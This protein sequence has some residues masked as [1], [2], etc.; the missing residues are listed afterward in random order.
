MRY[1]L[2]LL[3]IQQFERAAAADLRA[4]RRSGARSH[5]SARRRD[6]DRPLGRAGRDARTRSADARKALDRLRERTRRSTKANPV[7]LHA[8]PWCG[9]T[10]DAWQYGSPTEPRDCVIRCRDKSCAFADGLPVYVVDEDIY[11]VPADADH[12]DRR[13]VRD[14]CRGARRRRRSSTAT[15]D[16]PPP[17]LIIQD[18]L[19]LISGPLGTL[20]GLYETAI[21]VLCTRRRATAEGR[22]PRRRRSAAPQHQTRGLFDREMRQFPPPGLDAR[23]S[24]FAV[25][26]PA[27]R[28]GT[29]LYVGLMAPGASQATLMIRTYAALLQSAL[30]CRGQRRRRGTRTGRSSATS[31]A[32]ACSAAPACRCRTTSHDRL[33]LLAGERR[34]RRSSPTRASSSPAASRRRRSP[35]HLKRM[36]DR[37]PRRRR[38]RRHPRDEHDLGRRRHRPARPDGRDGP[39]AVD[40]RVHP[41]DEPRR[42]AATPGWS[43][44]CSTRRARATAR[45]TRRSRATTRALPP[46]RVDERHAV[47]AARARPRAPRGPDRPRAADDPGLARQR[48]GRSASRSTAPSSSVLDRADRRRGPTGRPGRGRRDRGG[49]R[50]SP[51]A[52]EQR[53]D[54]RRRPAVQLVHATLDKTLLLDAAERPTARSDTCPTPVVAARRRPGVEPLP[55]EE[56]MARSRARS[57]AVSS[58]R[59]TASA[60]SSRSRT[61]RSWSPASTAGTSASPNLH[62]P[63]LETRA[64]RPR[65]RRAAGHATATDI[66]VVRFPRWYSCPNASG[67]TITTSSPTLRLEQVRRLQPHAR[68]VALRGRLRARPHRRLPVHALGA[69]GQAAR[70]RAA[71]LTHRG[72]GHDGV[73]S[74]HRDHLQLRRR[75]ARWTRRSTGSRCAT[76]RVLRKPP[77]LASEQETCDEPRPRAAARRVERLVRQPPLG[78]LDPA[79]V[80]RRVPAARQ[81]LGHPARLVRSALATAIEAHEPRRRHVLHD[82]RPRRGRRGAEDARQDGE[83]RANGRRTHFRREEYDALL[84]G[85]PED[86]GQRSSPRTPASRRIAEHLVDAGDARHAASRGPGARRVQRGSSRPRRGRA[87][88]APLVHRATPAGCPRSRSRAKGSSSSA[89]DERTRRPVGAQPGRDRERRARTDATRRTR[90]ALGRSSPTG[91]SRRGSCSSTRSLTR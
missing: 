29:R 32:C 74:R 37:V 18:E 7:Q 77:W 60:R 4:A 45:T 53:G 81:A 16:C 89:P 83:D 42:P 88:L 13:Q 28:K 78:D 70:G 50:A 17:E 91:R 47:L 85:Q 79:V 11:R 14:A 2:R 43:S 10:L 9:A 1:T 58:S 75:S 82:R 23:D 73:A 59:P 6:L 65:L 52:L 26:A 35:R 24:C 61:S 38:A 36:D 71:R 19:H 41:G 55:G 72:H 62:E 54:D 57:G 68:P 67:S 46:G 21:D 31:T 84:A 33:E 34:A 8:C 27:R 63:R 69:R 64:R 25:E 51:R 66:P 12:R 3:T 80:G 48:V 20:A 44:R 90:R 87:T 40:V 15:S 56:L 39:A 86:S 76:S 30:G 49:A 5:D 22:S